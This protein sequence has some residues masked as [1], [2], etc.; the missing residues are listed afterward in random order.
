MVA[1]H[2]GGERPEYSDG[3][4]PD[5]KTPGTD[6][7]N[8]KDAFKKQIVHKDHAKRGACPQAVPDPALKLRAACKE[9]TGNA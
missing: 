1:Q 4:H 5:A 9:Y 6:G 3:Y 7:V 8:T 2:V